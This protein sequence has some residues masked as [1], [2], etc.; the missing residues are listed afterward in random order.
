MFGFTKIIASAGI[1]LVLAG[2]S[3]TGD[4][5]KPSALVKFSAEKNVK[6]L[7]S[8]DIGTS[9]GDK[10]HQLTPGVSGK[11]I[12]VTDV[13]GKVSSY[14]LM[15]GAALWST[16]LE[17]SI[18]SGVGA[19]ADTAIV[20]TYSGDVIALD[21]NT[22]NIRWQVPVGGEVVS[23]AQLN[24]QITVVRMI[25]GD[26]VALDLASGEQRWV[27]ASNQPN[28]TLR[29]TTSPMVALDATLTGLDNGKF[30]ALD[31]ANGDIL[32]Q[33]RISVAK[34]KSDIERLTDIDGIPV[35][36]KNIIYIP[37]YRG[38]LTAINPFTAEVLWRKPYSTYRS[39]A[40][41]NNTI[42]LSADNDVV[43][44]IDSQ[45]ASEVWRQDLLLNRSITSPATLSGQIVVGDKQG[46]LHFLAQED[47]HFVA[48][49]K[50]GG[51]LIGDLLVKNK[52]LYALSNNG[53][54]TAMTIE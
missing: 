35:L 41:G 16:D 40:S 29:G 9:F 28:L 4:E 34:G 46:Y 52:V 50:I 45:S 42:Y 31:N 1:A 2:C 44:A 17:V 26:V 54:L 3:S 12:I 13:S 6:V 25:N 10:Y 53:R 20:S 33:K 37:S 30:I 24:N 22:G 49:Y 21:A 7:W 36:Y 43:H 18:S 32:W 39:L 14:D 11:S 23:K 38:N 15:T 19:N 47:G 27:Y 51:A 5:I 8:K 48:R